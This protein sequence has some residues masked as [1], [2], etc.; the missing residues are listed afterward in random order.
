MRTEVNTQPFIDAAYERGWDVCFPCMVR[1]VPDGPSRMQFYRV[2][3]SQLD[4]ARAGFLGAPMRCL[5]C[6]ALEREGFQA[7]ACEELDGV[8]VPLVAF[9]DN[10]NRLGYGGGNYDRLLPRLRNDAVVAGVAFA[11]QRVDRVTAEPHDQALP[12]IVSA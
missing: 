12:R 5:A 3:R 11:E 2:S 10:G 8:L 6:A 4:A 7:V 1:D 9:D